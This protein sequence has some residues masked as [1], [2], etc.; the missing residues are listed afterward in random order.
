MKHRLTTLTLAATCLLLA[1]ACTQERVVDNNR[2]LSTSGQ[3]EVKVA[4]D[5]AE[6]S[7]QVEATHEDGASAKDEVDRRVN[8]FLAALAEQGF[9]RDHIVASSLRI[10]PRYEYRDRQQTFIGY[11]ASRDVTVTLEELESLNTLLDTAVDSG[12]EQIRNIA[13]KSSR[14]EEL[15]QEARQRA[16][17][18]S[19]AKARALAAGYDAELGPVAAIRYQAGRVDFPMAKEASVM[20]ASADDGGGQFLHDKITFTDTIEVEFDLIIKAHPAGK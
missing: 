14:E 3:G 17:A 1:T 13:L 7:M 2:T 20:R 15:K 9:D 5:R 18:D 11:T 16:I 19:R 8:R 6:V 10:H 4:P 12:I